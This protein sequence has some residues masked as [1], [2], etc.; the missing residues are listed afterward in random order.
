MIIAGCPGCPTHRAVCDEWDSTVA[1]RVASGVH[2]P[3]PQRL[4]KRIKI[5]ITVQQ[6]ISRKQAECS[7]PAVDRFADSVSMLAQ[8]T[9]VRRGRDRVFSAPPSGIRRT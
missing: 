4:L 6:L 5:A 8:R 2:H 3:Q 9:V 7:D 1:Y